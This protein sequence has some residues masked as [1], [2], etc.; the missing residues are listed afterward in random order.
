MPS[1]LTISTHSILITGGGS[2][3]GFA[4]AKRLANSGHEVIICGRRLEQLAQAKLDCPPLITIQADVGTEEGRNRLVNTIIS[5][6]PQVRS[7]VF[8]SA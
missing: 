3:I 6:Y 1:F 5:D 7:I 4:L 2:G 8:S